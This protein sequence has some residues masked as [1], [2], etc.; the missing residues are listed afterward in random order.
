MEKLSD[1]AFYKRYQLGRHGEVTEETDLDSVA[2]FKEMAYD[3]Y[4]E[5]GLSRMD[6]HSTGCYTPGM[7]L[8]TFGISYSS[9]VDIGMEIAVALYETGCPLLVHDA[10]NC[11]IFWRRRIV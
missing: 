2:S 6:V 7:W 8:I 1:V 3:H 5:L 9:R 4:G 11:W 10:Q